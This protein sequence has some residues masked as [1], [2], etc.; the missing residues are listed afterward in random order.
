MYGSPGSGPASTSRTAALSRT[1]RLTHPSVDAPP[2]P[3]P[4]CGPREIRPR[5]GFS[6]KRPQHDAGMRIEPP[7]SDAWATATMP[8]A[9]AAA[10]PPDEPPA[11]WSSAH[12]LWVGPNDI[13]SVVGVLP[14]SG[15]LVRPSTTKPADRRR[16]TRWLSSV[17]RWSM[18]LRNR[19]PAYAGSPAIWP[20]RSFNRIGT[21]RNGPSGRSP[22]ASA[23]AASNRSVITALTA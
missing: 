14:N 5:D 15:V 21:P 3:S 4:A 20:F 18:A 13:G 11:V 22:A 16:R 7:P 17:S 2:Q 10:E 12:G 8:A 6:P 9:T 1:V 23:R 19:V